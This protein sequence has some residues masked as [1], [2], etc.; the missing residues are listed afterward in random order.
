MSLIVEDGTMP[1][2]A[3]T[4]VSVSE[5][6]IYLAERS[7]NWPSAPSDVTPDA[8][9]AKKER[10][11]ILAADWLNT[12]EWKGEQV[13]PEW[14][15]AWPR[16]GVPLAP[17]FDGVMQFVP[18]DIVPGKVKQSQMKVADLIYSGTDFFAPIEH[19]GEVKSISESSSTTIDVITESTS[20]S[21]TY[22]E[23]APSD[24]LYPAI[25]GLIGK[26]LNKIPGKGSKM[27]CIRILK[28]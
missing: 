22:A 9:I 24:T 1:E 18:C 11:L 7:E 28:T 17:R 12:L 6:D 8:N 26:F 10:A 20:K 16:C 13:D 2:G 19:G 23:T 25:S 27:S 15:M 5:A 21:V 4:Y 3:N 14:D